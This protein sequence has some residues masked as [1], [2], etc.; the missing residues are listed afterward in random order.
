VGTHKIKELQ[1]TAMLDN[2]HILQKYYCKSAKD[3]MW[4]VAIYKV[5]QI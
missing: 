1:K 5:V 3:L 2:A 4:E